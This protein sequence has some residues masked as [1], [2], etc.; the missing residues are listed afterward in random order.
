MLQEYLNTGQDIS[1]NQALPISFHFSHGLLLF[2]SLL[3]ALFRFKQSKE[4]LQK[5]NAYLMTLNNQ[6]K[7]EMQEVLRYREEILKDLTKEDTLLFDETMVAYMRQAIYRMTD[8][9][10]LDAKRISMEELIAEV[11]GTIKLSDFPQMPD[12]VIQNKSK[13]PTIEVDRERIKQMLA[14]S[15]T[16]LYQSSD[17]TRSITIVLEDTKLGYSVAHMQNYARESNAL[18]IVLTIEKALP[19]PQSIYNLNHNSI[20][21]QVAR[22]GNRR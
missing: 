21:D 7:E 1:P 4:I 16:Y 22:D 3:I 11:R 12:L 13:Q 2:S 14:N 5:K 17:A 20:V 6:S 15:I 19:K 9:M 8:Y 18:R 10:R